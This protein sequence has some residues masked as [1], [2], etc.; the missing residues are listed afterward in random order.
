MDALLLIAGLIVVTWSVKYAI[1]RLLKALDEPSQKS[2]TDEK[3]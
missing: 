1:K 2:Q 3:L